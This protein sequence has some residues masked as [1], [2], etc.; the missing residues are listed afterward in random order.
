MG[1]RELE[2]R[3][4]LDE[5]GNAEIHITDTETSDH[6]YYE[7]SSDVNCNNADKLAKKIG[8]ELLSWVDIMR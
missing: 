7:V 4:E 3:I 8:Y 2:V 6:V 5:K 1:E